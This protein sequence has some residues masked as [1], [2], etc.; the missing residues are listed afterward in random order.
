MSTWTRRRA[1]GWAAAPLLIGA[2][3]AASIA[4]AGNDAIFWKNY[5]QPVQVEPTR[6]NI[7]YS[8]GFAWATGLTEWQGW[9]S[10]R[11][12]TPGV[13]HLNTCRPFCAAGHYKAYR[14]RVTL[15][16]V[17]R[18]NGQRR[19]VDIKVTV[20]GKPPGIWGSNCKGLQIVN[21]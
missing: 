6:I 11:A 8:T 4:T 9:G 2:A 17:R 3:L 10:T 18:C 1:L 12:S 16:K 20:P 7:N 21:P 5:R 15:Y 13:I 19:Y 14:G